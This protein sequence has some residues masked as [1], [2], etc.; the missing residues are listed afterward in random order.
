MKYNP[1]RIRIPTGGLMIGEI[2]PP[3]FFDEK[4]NK[5]EI[6]RLKFSIIFSDSGIPKIDFKTEKS[7]AIAKTSGKTA[8]TK[9][10]PIATFLLLDSSRIRINLK[11]G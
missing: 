5:F 3:V 7:F 2:T 11:C 10:I 8:K 9:I 6:K 1:I 4:L